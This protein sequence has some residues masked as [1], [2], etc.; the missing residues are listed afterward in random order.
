MALVH[1]AARPYRGI[2]WV[3]G[4]AVEMMECAKCGNWHEENYCPLDE[5]KLIEHTP[6]VSKEA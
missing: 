4:E 6:K 5:S 2:M 1:F 3:D